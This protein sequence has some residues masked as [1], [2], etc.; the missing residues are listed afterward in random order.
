MGGTLDSL[1]ACH[2]VLELFILKLALLRLGYVRVIAA[3][4]DWLIQT[5]LVS[6]VDEAAIAPVVAMCTSAVDQLL[7]GEVKQ[8]TGSYGMLTL[9]CTRGG[10]GPTA[11]AITLV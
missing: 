5:V 11:A 9:E 8:L 4:V 7:D 1:R 2:L 3:F 6:I 10:D